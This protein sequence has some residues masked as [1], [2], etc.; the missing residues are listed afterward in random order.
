MA[1][2]KRRTIKMDVMEKLDAIFEET[3]VWV[4]KKFPEIAEN[5][6]RITI[7]AIMKMRLELEKMHMKQVSPTKTT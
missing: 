1:I 7:L 5:N 2:M 6:R 3:A 4:D